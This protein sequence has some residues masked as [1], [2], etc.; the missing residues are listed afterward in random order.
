MTVQ[1]TATRAC[2]DTGEE[3]L[4]RQCAAI[5]AVDNSSRC[6]AYRNTELAMEWMATQRAVMQHPP[7]DAAQTLF[8]KYQGKQ[9]RGAPDCV[10]DST[11]PFGIY[12]EAEMTANS[13]DQYFWDHRVATTREFFARTVAMGASAMGSALIDG[14]YLDD[15]LGLD[16]EHPHAPV[17]M[18][19]THQQ[20][21]QVA[22]AT[23]RAVNETI[24]LLLP[25]G[26]YLLQMFHSAT[27]PSRKGCAAA[28]RAV[29]AGSNN[30]VGS[31][32][33][34]EL[35]AGA[36]AAVLLTL[37]QSV[38]NTTTRALSADFP[39]A[40]AAFLILRPS[41]GFLSFG[42]WGWGHRPDFPAILNT[43]V[44]APLGLCE[45]NVPGVFSR[46]YTHGLA[47]VRCDDFTHTIPGLKLDDVVASEATHD[48]HRWELLWSDDFA[49]PAGS[50]PNPLYWSLAGTD[51]VDPTH[52]PVEQQ[53]YVPE[54]VTL[55]GNGHCVIETKKERRWY[56]GG[57]M[58]KRWYNF[59]SGWM[60]SKGKVNATYGKWAVRARL[61]DPKVRGIW[62]AHWMLPEPTS[63]NC[64]PMGGEIDIM[65]ANGG[66]YGNTVVGTYS[67]SKN[68]SANEPHPQPPLANCT[69][70]CGCDLFFSKGPRGGHGLNGH[71]NCT[72]TSPWSC[73]EEHDFS[74]DFHVFS[75]TWNETA[76]TWAVDDVEYFSQ[77]SGD[78]AGLY[79][80]HWPMYFVL[81]TALQPSSD[82][83]GAG[84]IGEYPVRH[85]ID[86][87]RIYQLKSDGAAVP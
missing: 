63:W 26:K 72:W 80:P 84:S 29:C 74:R 78:P 76:I 11:A 43:D 73:K 38:M 1:L 19:M 33:D 54:A 17:R 5:K 71:Y 18:N 65:E 7:G 59:T 3:L 48:G 85:T 16:E 49:G 23:R 69:C 15:M 34:P 86:W 21:V 30:H 60:E 68:C 8:L 77:V 2:A 55:D 67:W 39:Q 9:P 6:F 66:I 52:G 28:F 4:L 50:R 13:G 20:V 35:Y 14:L 82:N 56:P 37:D 41:H 12:C 31:S 22:T 45:E 36:H 40:V 32:G 57:T 58:P 42:T 25:A 47:S 61:P 64:W 70:G 46:R 83:A 53:L 44:G 10:R 27:L 81:N 24:A 75:I 62:P 87:A 79:V 51:G